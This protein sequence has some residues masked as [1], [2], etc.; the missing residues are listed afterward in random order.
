MEE[1]ASVSSTAGTTDS[2]SVLIAVTSCVGALLLITFLCLLLLGRKYVR[3]S[4]EQSEQGAS[5]ERGAAPSQESKETTNNSLLRFLRELYS[6][7][8][9][10]KR[11]LL[12]S[13]IAIAYTLHKVGRTAR[14]DGSPDPCSTKK[15]AEFTSAAS[16]PYVTSIRVRSYCATSRWKVAEHSAR[17]APTPY[18]PH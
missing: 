17:Y 3:L 2:S 6:L 10:D 1:P 18:S 12:L 16:A 11:L 4:R 13:S 9:P 7:L 15:P 14:H 5:F 8:L